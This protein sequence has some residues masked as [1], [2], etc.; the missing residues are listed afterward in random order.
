[1]K[2]IHMLLFCFA[3]W[4]QAADYYIPETQNDQGAETYIGIVNPSDIAV[5]LSIIGY[6]L[7][8]EEYGPTQTLSELNGYGMFW[9]SLTDLFADN[10]DKIVWLKISSPGELEVFAEIWKE[11]V[12]SAFWAASELEGLLYM[13]HVAQDIE[14]FSTTICAVNG[15]KSGSIVNLLPNGSGNESA[16][17][18]LENAFGKAKYNLLDLWNDISGINWVLLSGRETSTAAME[19]FTYNNQNRMAALG[20]DRQ[21]G[22]TIRFLHVAD[23]VVNYWTGMVYINLGESE[24]LITERYF[25]ASGTVIK[26]FVPDPLDPNGKITLLFDVS[27]QDR[28]PPGTAWVEVTSTQDLVGY[29]LFGSLNGGVDQT[30]AGI[31]GSYQTGSQL[32]YP[33]FTA[34]ENSWSG[35]VAVNLGAN[36]ADLTFE[37]MDRDGNLLDT[38]IETNIAPNQKFVATGTQLFPDKDSGAW[39]RATGIQSRWAGFLLWGDRGN[40]RNHLSGIKAAVGESAQ[41]TDPSE[42]KLAEFE[43]TLERLRL[44]MEIPGLS[45]AITKNGRVVWAKGFG[46]A[47]VEEDIPATPTTS[48]HLASLTKTFA[49]TIIMQLVEQGLLDLQEPVSN[50]GIDLSGQ[51]GVV[52]VIHLLTHTSEGTPGTVYRY[53]GR[54]FGLLEIVVQIASGRTFCELLVEKI[55]EP[56]ALENTAPNILDPSNCHLTTEEQR[57]EF[58]QNLAQGY[59][60]DGQHPWPY[61]AIFGTSAGLISSAMDV[62]K[63]SIAIDNNMFLSP[64]TKELV[65]TPY[66]SSY[67]GSLPYGLGW[68]VQHQADVKILWH[69]GYWIANSS[70]IIKVPELDL[71]FVVLA[72]SDRL[73]SSSPGIGS[74]GDVS[75]S[76]VAREFLAAFVFE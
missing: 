36:A 23:D 72:N 66:V 67:G 5:G 50:F 10:A 24:A 8:G 56:L 7:G 73:S 16:M 68:F 47:N 18:E 29:E 39:V 64:E 40:T 12:R 15:S 26:Q 32:D 60:S 17:T 45:A 46:H 61:P 74:D 63:Y 70:L 34:S 21:K 59:G 41:N 54:R 71:A 65:F 22:K 69:Y 49:S 14:I 52:R 57:Q 58:G 2:P 6:D 76:E 55:I 28:V 30:F 42:E 11:G 33:Y 38:Q 44:Q 3:A 31:Q 4:C 48:F 25:D 43:G 75:C 9:F 62:A 35:F 20:L 1:M 13:P 53:N 51:G 19:R 37:L 27:N